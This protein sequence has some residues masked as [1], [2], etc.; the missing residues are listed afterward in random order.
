L[1]VRMG[2]ASWDFQDH[3]VDKSSAG[4]VRVDGLMNLCENQI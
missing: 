4:V 1:G 3:H 2:Q